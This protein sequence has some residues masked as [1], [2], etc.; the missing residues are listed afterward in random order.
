MGHDGPGHVAIAA[1]QPTLRALK[2]YHG[3]RGAGLCVEFKVQ[4]RP[5]HHRRL[6]PDRR[7]HAEA[8]RRRGRVDPGRRPSG[9]ATP[10]APALRPAAR[11][12][13]S[14]AGA[15]RARRI[16]SRSASATSPPRWPRSRRCSA[17][18]TPRWRADGAR[19]LPPARAPGAARGVPRAPP[20][21]LAR[22]APGAADH[23]LAQLLPLPATT[24]ACSSATW[25]R[26]TSRRSLAGDGGDGRQRALAGGDGGVL[27]AAG[28]R[29]ARHRLPPPRGG[30]PPCLLRRVRRDRSRRDQRPRGRPARTRPAAS[31]SRRS[32]A[33]PTG[34]CAARRPAL[35]PPEPLRRVAARAAARRRP[36]PWR[37]SAST[38]GAWT[39]A[40]RPAAARS[41]PP[42]PLPRR[43]HGRDDRPPS[44]ASRP[45]SQYA[46]TG[47][48]TLPFNT[49]LPAPRDEDAPALAAAARLAL[50]PDLFG[51]GSPASWRTSGPTPRPPACSTRAPGPGRASSSAASACPGQL[52][53]TSSIRASELGATARP[54][55][56]RSRPG[57]RRRRPRHRR[58]VRAPPRSPTTAQRDP[59][60]AGPGRCSA[61]SCRSPVID[62]R[63]REAANFTNEG[64]VAGTTRLLKNIMGLWLVQECR[65]TW[66]EGRPRRPTTSSPLAEAPAVRRAG[67]PRRSAFLR[68]GDMP[69]RIAA[70]CTR[71]GQ[72]PPRDEGAFVRCCLESLALKY[73]WT[74]E[75]LEAILGTTIETIH[76]VGGGVE[77]R[78]A[79]PVHRRRLRPS[80]PR[81]PG[82]GH[83]HRQRPDAGPRRRRARL[84]GRPA[85]RRAASADPVHCE[86]GRRPRRRRRDLPPLPRR[87][88]PSAPAAHEP[89]RSTVTYRTVRSPRHRLSDEGSTSPGEGA[90]A[91][92]VIETPSWGY[93][94]SG[95]RF[96]VFPQPGRPR[97][98]RG[99]LDD[100]AEVHRLTGTAGAVAMHFPWDARG[101]LRALRAHVEAA[102]LRVGAV[103]PNLFEDP[104]YRLGSVANPDAAIRRKRRA[105]ARLRRTPPC[106]ARRASGSGCRRHQRP[107]PGLLPPPQPRVIDA[108]ARC[109]RARRRAAPAGRVQAVRARALPHGHG[110]LGPGAAH[111]PAARRARAGRCRHRPP[112][113]RHQHRAD[114]RDPAGER[115]GS[116]ASTSTTASTPTTT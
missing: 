66:G 65:R 16:T 14:S 76:V 55:R 88:R 26:R 75:R 3:K 115:H 111:L 77:E 19:L 39:T 70:F 87:D 84:A 22:D 96:G 21:R 7:G 80:G 50:V 60:S 86:P 61:S 57:L 102:G 49:R 2:L 78:P 97:D 25:R 81:R 85:G 110:R 38:P 62:E 8:D 10:T 64:G 28:R 17:S 53:A 11:P 58:R 40:A 33:S 109:T 63:P 105:S 59:S 5:D 29:A 79:L 112:R 100:A 91:A 68:P 69:A 13:S 108:L 24:T 51:L 83:R 23:G 82:R 99:A 107:G 45:T 36:G 56:A 98:V 116:A 54:P 30:L 31:S 114:R 73:R 9:S 93:G 1:G 90:L 47:I 72:A 94:D 32:T 74:I 67:R 95:T 106:S 34:R 35:E 18:S 52:F 48:Q 101:R 42:V 6:H 103:N 37:A 46:I 41:G 27:R 43:A 12:R 20:R 44:P 104:D 92:L 113:A 89:T 71:T 4:L 15:R